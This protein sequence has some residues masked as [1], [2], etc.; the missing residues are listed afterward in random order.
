VGSSSFDDGGKQSKSFRNDSPLITVIIATY[1]CRDGLVKTLDVL[2]KQTYKNFEVIVVD[3]S[4]QVDTVDALKEY[5]GKI[6]FWI[7]EK[8]EGIYDAWNK[9]LRCSM[10]SWVC[11]LGAGDYFEENS[12]ARYVE[13]INKSKK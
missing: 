4:S 2:E 6:S 9:G 5:D 13:E 1:N 7:S 12:I 11:F 10:G 3:G 8:D